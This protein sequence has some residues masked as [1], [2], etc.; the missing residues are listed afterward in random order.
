MSTADILRAVLDKEIGLRTGRVLSHVMLY[1]LSGYH[2][3]F[4]LPTAA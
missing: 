3:L 2:R 1:E 4:S